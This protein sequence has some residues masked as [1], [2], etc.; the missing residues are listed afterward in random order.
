MQVV[1]KPNQASLLALLFLSTQYF[2]V[3]VLAVSYVLNQ[4]KAPRT[5][6]SKSLNCLQHLH[7]AYLNLLSF[8]IE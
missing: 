3:P 2:A 7:S 5:N 6:V 8:K 1:L 4:T